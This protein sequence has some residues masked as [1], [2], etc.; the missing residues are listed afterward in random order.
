M[1]RRIRVGAIN[2]L[3]TTPLIHR[4]KWLA[5]EIELLLDLPSRLADQ[6]GAGRSRRR[7]YPNY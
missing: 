3:N 6:L 5:P 4:L 1:D 2:Y 7:P